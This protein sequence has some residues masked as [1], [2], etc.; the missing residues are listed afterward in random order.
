MRVWGGRQIIFATKYINNCARKRCA[1]H[2]DISF[3][4][5]IGINTTDGGI[6]FISFSWMFIRM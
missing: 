3:M 1:G 4:I 6:S 2:G 5:D